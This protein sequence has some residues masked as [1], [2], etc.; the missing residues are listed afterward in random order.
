[1]SEYA[2]FGG[3]FAAQVMTGAGCGVRAQCAHLQEPSCLRG[4]RGAQQLFGELDMRA[5]K[6]SAAAPALIQDPNQVDNDVGA[7]QRLA[8]KCVVAVAADMQ[9]NQRQHAS[10]SY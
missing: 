2:L 4:Y 5:P 1:M 10:V 9:L 7:A 8:Q 6:P 3:A